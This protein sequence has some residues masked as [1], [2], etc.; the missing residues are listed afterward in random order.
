MAGW[1]HRL[2]GHKF[3]WTLVGDGRGSLVCSDSLGFIQSDTTEQLNWTDNTATVLS[4]VF[5]GQDVSAPWP[6]IKPA[7]PALEGKLSTIGPAA[8]SQGAMILK[9][10]RKASLSSGLCLN[11]PDHYL[12]FPDFCYHASIAG[13]PPSDLCSMLIPRLHV[14]WA[15]SVLFPPCTEP[16]SSL[17]H[18]DGIQMGLRSHEV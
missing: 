4:F 3:E 15:K 17:T 8:K 2:D 7:G 6:Q 12:V 1:H 10:T 16:A 9:S 18:L 11:K 14:A 13:E 5:F